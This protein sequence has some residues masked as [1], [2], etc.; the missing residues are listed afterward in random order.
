MAHNSS[1]K[2]VAESQGV[3]I[4]CLATGCHPCI[5]FMLL[6]PFEAEGL[7]CISVPLFFDTAAGKVSKVIE[8][9]C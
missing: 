1:Q 8:C 3:K 6:T 5:R 9:L 4:L 7:F 2:R